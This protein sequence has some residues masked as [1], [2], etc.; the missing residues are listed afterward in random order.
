M[1]ACL[2][3]WLPLAICAERMIAISSAGEYVNSGLCK[4]SYL[5]L[6]LNAAA[7][8]LLMMIM[9]V[10]FLKRNNL[11]DMALIVHGETDNGYS[12]WKLFLKLSDS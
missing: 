2:F 8:M 1:Q 6:D 4:S 12:G 5:T 7:G 3:Q 11:E 9:F 10:T